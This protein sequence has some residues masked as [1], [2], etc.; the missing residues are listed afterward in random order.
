MKGWLLG[1]GVAVVFA[2]VGAFTASLWIE[3][4]GPTPPPPPPP[5]EISPEWRARRIRVEVLNGVGIDGLARAATE[6]LRGWGF[7]VVYYGNASQFD[8][9]SSV[10][11]ARV[12]SVE[13]ARRVADALGIPKV[14]RAPDEE[15]YLDVTV[16]LGEDW[17]ATSLPAPAAEEP[18]T[19]GLWARIKRAA[20]RLAG[21]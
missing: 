16:V 14:R 8:R 4:R 17:V 15:L 2:V 18:Q 5:D 20:R 19:D 9:D 11:I 3:I 21:S 10:V 13:P 7:D 12:A 1:V 6:Q